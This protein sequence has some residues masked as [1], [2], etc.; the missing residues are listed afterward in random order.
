MRTSSTACAAAMLLAL[1]AL[2]PRAALAACKASIESID[3]VPTIDYAPFENRQKREDFEV[4]VRNDGNEE[5]AVA[6]AIASGTTGSQ[7]F[8]RKGSDNLAYEVLTSNGSEYSN[9]ID[10]PAGS[11]R[12]KGGKGEDAEIKVRLRIPAGLVSPAGN[13]EDTLRLRLFDVSGASPV[14]LGPERNVPASARIQARAQLN[15]AGTAG[16]FGAPFELDEIDFGDMTTGAT[17]D[18]V[19]QVRATSQVAITLSSRNLGVLKHTSLPGTA[20]VPYSL[21]VDGTPVDLAG[22]SAPILRTPDLTLDGNSY[23]MRVTI[24]N[25]TGRAAGNYKDRI[26]IS[27]M[28]Q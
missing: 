14:P 12:L 7:R 10:A 19:V 26:T 11:T 3:K 1:S 13:Y 2:E 17:R 8:Y 24:G 15:I 5:C 23:P 25:T 27:V 28:P 22:S 20:G 21:T 18:A 4:E 9:A 6:L 16:K